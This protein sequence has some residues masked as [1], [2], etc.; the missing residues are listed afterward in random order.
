MD[1]LLKKNDSLIIELKANVTKIG[2][3]ME[4]HK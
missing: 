2:I 4:K 3:L 1:H